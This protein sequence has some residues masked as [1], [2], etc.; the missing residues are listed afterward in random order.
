MAVNTA[1]YGRIFE[2]RT[3]TFDVEKRPSYFE[4]IT[5]HNV[6]VQGKRGNIAQV[7]LYPEVLSEGQRVQIHNVLRDKWGLGAPLPL[8]PSP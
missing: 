1:Q 3:Y 5:I 4:G 8:P 6:N 2:D 7:I